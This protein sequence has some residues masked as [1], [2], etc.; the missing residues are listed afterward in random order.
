M[1]HTYKIIDK[2]VGNLKIMLTFA[3]QRRENEKY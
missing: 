1:Q 2:I 3:E